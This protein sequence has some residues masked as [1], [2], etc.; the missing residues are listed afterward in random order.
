MTISLVIPFYNEE[1]KLFEYT[2]VPVT[3]RLCSRVVDYY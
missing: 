2:I 1:K 3:S